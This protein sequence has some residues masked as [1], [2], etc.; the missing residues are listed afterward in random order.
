[1]TEQEK[2]LYEKHELDILISRGVDFDVKAK[3]RE[4]RTGI[5]GRIGFRKL[6]EKT[7]KF[8]IQEPTLAVLDK[9]AVEQLNFAFDEKDIKENGVQVAKKLVSLHGKKMA[10]IV[11]IAVAGQQNLKNT[12]LIN[13]LTNLLFENVKPSQL[14]Q[15]AMLINTMSNLGDFMSSIRLMSAARTT[16]P[17]LIESDNEV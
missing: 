2:L 16:M 1:M 11:A 7:V 4:K 13:E 5:L 9:I 15:L 12:K 14:M 8:N 3:V 17:I 10:R 6:V